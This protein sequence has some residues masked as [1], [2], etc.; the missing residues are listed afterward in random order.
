MSEIKKQYEIDDEIECCVYCGTEKRSFQCCGEV[1]Y[2][3]QYKIVNLADEKDYE[4][5]TETE[6]EKY[7]LTK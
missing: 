5:I 3:T 6:L 4:Y 1:H 7:N 2:E